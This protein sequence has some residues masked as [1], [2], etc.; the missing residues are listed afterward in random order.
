MSRAELVEALHDTW[1]ISGED[2]PE[3]GTPEQ[4]LR[5][6]LKYAVLAPSNHNTQPWRFHIEKDHVDLYADRARALPVVDPDDRELVI[7]CGAA[8]FQLCIAM[9]RFGHEDDI[10][11]LPDPENPDLLARVRLGERW[12]ATEEEHSLFDAILLRRTNRMPFFDRGVPES[13]LEDLREAAE[14]QSAW[15]HIVKSDQDRNALAALITEGDRIQWAD[16]RFRRELAAWLHPNRKM[17]MDGMPGQALGWGNLASMTGPLVIRTFD[18]GGGKAARDRELVAGSPVLAVLG[19]KGDTPHDWLKAGEALA[20]VL[21][22]AAVD[23]VSASYLN[24]PIEVP[25]LRVT[26]TDLLEVQGIEGNPQIILRMGYGPEPMLS[27]R[28]PVSEVLA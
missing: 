12:H 23:R 28:R 16:K 18:M 3:H 20:R 13:L 4:K 15:L 26:L 2:Y 5:F 25:E 21:L 22:R 24:Q 7:G 9:R 1:Q 17:S 8:L 6:L 14:K 19:T 11:C 10:V 27:P